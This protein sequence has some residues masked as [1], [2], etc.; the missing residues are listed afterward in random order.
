M[1]AVEPPG[2]APFDT[3]AACMQAGKK[4]EEVQGTKTT[5][6]TDFSVLLVKPGTCRQPIPFA[7]FV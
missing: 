1:R 5:I 2:P 3:W 6:C 7:L 4:K